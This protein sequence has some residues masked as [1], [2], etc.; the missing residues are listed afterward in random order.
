[1]TEPDPRTVDLE[2]TVSGT[3]EQVWDAIAT[4]PGIS[5]WLHPTHVDEQVGGTFAFDMGGGW[6]EGG[7]VTTHDAPTRFATEVPWSTGDRSATVATEWLVAAR[8]DGTCTVRMV[9]SGF[10]ADD[11]WDDEID[12]LREGMGVALATLRLYLA[13][14]AGRRPAVVHAGGPVAGPP[15]AAF[16]ALLADAG[17]DG[18]RVGD[19]VALRGTPPL[20]GTV[21]VLSPGRHRCD[22]VLLV[23]ESAPGI[24]DLATYAADTHA[25]VHLTLF[26]G[27]GTE[28]AP[29]ADRERPRWQAWFADLPAREAHR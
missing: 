28:A 23:D 26:D 6:S 3:P 22:V 20:A 13:H 5:S 9:M 7:R 21:E 2:V 4:G 17:L 19:R 25:G 1:M 11:A 8:D 18:T 12:A 24:A 27:P 14:F 10:G 16:G 29:V 15:S